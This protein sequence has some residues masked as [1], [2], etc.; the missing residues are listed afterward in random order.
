MGCSLT[1]A[2]YIRRLKRPRIRH[3]S[4]ISLKP[5]KTELTK[6]KSYTE[7]D[8]V[9][10]NVFLTVTWENMDLAGRNGK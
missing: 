5:R 9:S 1:R 10:S 4:S 2:V 6:L 3:A 7:H 8:I